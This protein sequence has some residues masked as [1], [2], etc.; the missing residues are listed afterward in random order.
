M[1]NSQPI[2]GPW[3]ATRLWNDIIRTMRAEMPVRKHKKNLKTYENC[4]S[5][6]EVIDWLHK[7]LQKNSN[8]G[9]DVTREQTLQLLSK[10]TR[11][12]IIENVR[13]ADLQEFREGELFRLSNKSPVR[14]IRTPGKADKKGDGGRVVL[15]DLGNTPRRNLENE[16][17]N[18]DEKSDFSSVEGRERAEKRDESGGRRKREV[19]RV[20]RAREEAVKKQLNL[21]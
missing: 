20:R 3:R 5:S 19:S 17:N 18:G 7:N 15:G 11:A 2:T 14:N 10:L 9:T 1:E 13:E 8:F 16:I 6:S 12:G 4:F 21:S